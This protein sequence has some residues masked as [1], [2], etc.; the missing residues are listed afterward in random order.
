MSPKHPYVI[1]DFVWTGMNYLGE[2]G[3]ATHLIIM[4]NYFMKH[5]KSQRRKMALKLNE[6]VREAVVTRLGY[7]ILPLIGIKNPLLRGELH[8]FPIKGFP[9]KT[10]WRLIWLKDKKLSPVANAYLQFVGESKERIVKDY[11][12][13]YSNFR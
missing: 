9:I 4:E 8:I 6:A 7:S 10:H 12:E 11:F 3:S 13:W 1:G 5:D 2:S